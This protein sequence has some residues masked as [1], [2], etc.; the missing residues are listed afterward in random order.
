VT[1]DLLEVQSADR[2]GWFLPRDS[3]TTSDEV[4]IQ[5]IYSQLTEVEPSAMISELAQDALFRL[6]PPSIRSCLRAHHVLRKWLVSKIVAARLGIQTRRARMEL[7]LRAIEICR[8]RSDLDSSVFSLQEQPVI[9][10]FVEAVLVAAVV[11][12]ESR[13]H[14][15]AWINVANARKVPPDSLTAFLSQPV[16][17]PPSI[18]SPLVTDIGWTLERMLEIISL[19]NLV[20]MNGEGGQML[21]NFDKR[22][23]VFIFSALFSS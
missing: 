11:S 14:Q 16:C 4:D 17:R 5:T 10:A 6:L 7:L 18:K 22:R 9:P 15:R 8:R 19:S 12:V 1:A 21:V 13:M 23:S 2:M 3:S 20:E